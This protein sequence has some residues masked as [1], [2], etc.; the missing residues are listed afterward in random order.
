[1]RQ[2]FSAMHMFIFSFLGD[3]KSKNDLNL[4]GSDAPLDDALKDDCLSVPELLPSYDDG[5]LDETLLCFFV[6]R[7]L[8]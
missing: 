4:V 1:M 8:R 5:F 2:D 6:N 7:L 3:L